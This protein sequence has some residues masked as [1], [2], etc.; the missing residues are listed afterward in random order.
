MQRNHLFRFT[1]SAV[2]ALTAWILLIAI[3]PAWAQQQQDPPADQPVRLSREHY[4]SGREML[5]VFRAVVRQAARATVRIRCE[6][7]NCALGSVIEPDG[8]ILT[9]ASEM[10]EPIR[11]RLRNGREYPAQLMG[12]D[13]LN[14][15]AMIKIEAANLATIQWADDDLSIGQWAIT[16]GQ[17][18]DPVA[19]GV[20]SVLERPISGQRPMIGVLLKDHEDGPV[21]QDV[22]KGSGAAKAGLQAGDVIV[23]ADGQDVKNREELITILG[24]FTSGEAVDLKIRRGDEM[25][26]KQ[27]MLM[28]PR[29]RSFDRSRIQNRLGGELSDRNEGFESVFQHDTVI[30]PSDCGSPVVGI[31]GKAIGLNIARAGRVASYALPA[32]LIQPKIEDL[33]S[34]KL[35]P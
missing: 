19:V 3:A 29:E 20:V 16:A 4:T 5:K 18:V 14:D 8:W 24:R 35:K 28:A 17:G 34:G 15:L 2:S 6:G 12:V 9:K 11:V 7:Q 22:V 30:R 26:D 21:V 27:I 32:K 25:L 31:D 1:S 10:K 13:K 33:K 23:Q